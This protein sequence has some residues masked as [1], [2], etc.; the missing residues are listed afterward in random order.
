MALT[1][2]R[3]TTPDVAKD[4]C[5]GR[6]D[7]DVA[8]TFEH[9]CRDVLARLNPADVIVTSPLKRCYVLADYI[10]S[11][12]EQPLAVDDRIQEMD[13]GTW[14]G[15]SWSD[16]PRDELDAWSSSFLH[17]RPHGG[18]S[19]AMLKE[20]TL[21]ALSDF[22][23]TGKSYIIVTHSG[24]IKA[25]WSTGSAFKNFQTQVDYGGILQAPNTQSFET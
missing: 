4:I 2:V 7:L 14:E 11:S 10:A 17:A 21:N 23:S 25:A 5:Y 1:F 18:E 20:R 24:V 3:H 16:I 15:K 22:A 9:E 12:F 19:V 6:T 8:D 13:F